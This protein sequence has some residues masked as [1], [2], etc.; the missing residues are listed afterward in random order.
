MLDE[1]IATALNNQLT[2]ERYSEAVYQSLAAQLDA[3]NLT[4]MRDYLLKRAGEEHSHAEKFREFIAD[5]DSLPVIDAL[6]KPEVELGSDLIQAGKAAFTL[7]LEHERKVTARI[8]AL[9]DLARKMR[10]PQ[11]EVWLHWFLIEQVEE[12]R[13][14]E[15][16]LT[17][18]ALADSGTGILLIDRML[19]EGA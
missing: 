2:F 10:D 11:T 9:F 7:A 16:I 5:R 8:S 15:E 13:S 3:L 14:L 19:G 1:I 12:E 18:F 6:P 4:G 17:R